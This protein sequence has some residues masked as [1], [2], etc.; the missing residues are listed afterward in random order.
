MKKRRKGNEKKDLELFRWSGSGIHGLRHLPPQLAKWV[1]GNRVKCGSQHEEAS[2]ITTRPSSTYQK[3]EVRAS[4]VAIS[5][6]AHST[7]FKHNHTESFSKFPNFTPPSVFHCTIAL[8]EFRPNGGPMPP[9]FS[10]SDTY[11]VSHQIYY[12]FLSATAGSFLLLPHYCEPIAGDWA[13]IDPS[14][15]HCTGARKRV[16][17][18]CI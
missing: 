15:P 13:E 17:E 8:L 11:I 18:N 16:S 7:T 6:F 10:R 1:N 14:T 3:T 9:L 2:P 4:P 12:L 5:D